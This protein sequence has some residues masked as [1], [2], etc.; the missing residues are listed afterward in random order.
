MIAAPWPLP[1]VQQV[2]LTRAGAGAILFAQGCTGLPRLHGLNPF[3]P[4]SLEANRRGELSEAQRREYGG[5]SQQRRLGEFGVAACLVATALLIGLGAVPGS[6]AALRVVVPSVCLVLAVMLSVHALSGG[7]ALNRDV[8]AGQVRSVEG[9][10][11]K[12]R[13]TGTGDSEIS[14]C[15]FYIADTRFTV[16]PLTYEAA[17]DGGYVRLFFL[18]LSRKV[19]NLEMLPDPSL[20]TPAGVAP[21][22]SATLVGAL[23]AAARALDRRRFNDA[24]GGVRSNG[25]APPAA[26]P[27]PASRK[28]SPDAPPLAESLLGTWSN[29]WMRV[30]FAADGS[31]TSSVGGREQAG[32]WSVGPDGR[33]NADLSGQ[34]LAGEAW[35][36][37][38]QLTITAEGRRLTLT[39]QAVDGVLQS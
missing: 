32:R 1:Q 5:L 36:D 13:L 34:R 22:N 20:E 24:R 18:P 39:R 3:P 23:G 37:G 33:L 17:P 16:L 28:P 8:R 38:D 2:L 10:V 14:T 12:S 31:V 6:N 9:T 11:R 7:N 26:M 25:S 15:Y 29:D 19:I 21:Q 30:G 27:P 35:V 4:E